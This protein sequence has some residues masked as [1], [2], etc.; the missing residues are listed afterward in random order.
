MRA[1]D[2]RSIDDIAA[3]WV[4]REDRAPL[5]AGDAVA[6]DAWLQADVRHFGA[7]ARAHA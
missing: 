3:A 7:Y 2:E 6:R 4:A 5:P 1:H